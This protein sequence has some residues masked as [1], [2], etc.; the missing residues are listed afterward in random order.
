MTYSGRN[1]FEITRF[2]GEDE[3]HINKKLPKELLLR[4]LSYL[5]V[6]SLCRC[7]QVS[8]L[9]NILALDGS[10][11]QRIDLFEFQRD[12][13]GPVIENI[14]QRCG[15][16]LRQLS[17]RGCES[18]GDGS[19][20]TLAHSCP[21]IEDLNLNKCKKIT[22]QT[23]QA[24]GRRF[25]SISLN[26]LSQRCSLTSRIRGR[27][28][29][30]KNHLM[31]HFSLH[32]KLKSFICRGCK[33]VN[34]RAVSCLATYC[35]DLE[36]LNVQG[37]DIL[38]DDS[39]TKL[40][41]CMRRLC[42][43]GCSRLTDASL[44]AL[45]S[46]CPDLV[47]L[48]LAQC[49]QLTDAGFQALARSCR[50]LERMD[51]EE[52]VLITDATLVHLAMGC[53]RLEKLTLSHCELIT[54][55]GIKQLSMSPCAAEHLTVLGLDN[56]PLVTDVALEHLVYC[57]NLQLIELYDCQLITRN[58]IRKLRNHL[59]Y[60]KVHAYFAPVTPPAGGGGARPRY[61]RCCAI[62]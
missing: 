61:C 43:S 36:V 38:T 49:T 3:N 20:K 12:V 53:P 1:K 54:D 34:D 30:W 41:P 45:A 18:I 28:I 47:T 51:L 27:T 26:V 42:V 9:W 2:T 57:H 52:C 10:N 60:I 29:W 22:D 56:C 39:I 4:I 33:N 58:A 40:G 50:L 37:C 8:K 14:S 13:E 24:L 62:V 48:E 46:R 6:V 11:W 21:N 16:F 7:A 44:L 15:G 25:G 59:P 19:M 17:L 55:Y 32:P 5:D 23:C 31:M 35:P